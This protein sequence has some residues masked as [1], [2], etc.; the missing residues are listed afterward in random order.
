MQSDIGSLRTKVTSDI[1]TLRTDMKN[2]RW[3]IGVMIAGASV[4]V[5]GANLLVTLAL[6]T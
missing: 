2:M 5:A 4:L 3:M 1:E 6:R